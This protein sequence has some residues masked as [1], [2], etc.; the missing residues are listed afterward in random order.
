MKDFCFRCGCCC[1]DN[2]ILITLNELELIERKIGK[3]NLDVKPT[4]N[5]I[6]E[7]TVKPCPFYTNG[8]CS[9]HNI[10]PAMCRMYHCGKASPDAP[11]LE[12]ISEI[13]KL[14]TENKEY[15]EY[16]LKIE[17]EAAEWGNSHGWNWRR[18]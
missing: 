16:R 6:W 5:N 1:R 13:K 15:A 3:T 17:S 2:K 9:I 18:R 11:H 4:I 12:W 14:I 10:R 8:L 7:W